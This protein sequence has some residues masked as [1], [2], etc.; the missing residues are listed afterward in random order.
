MK[1]H[2]LVAQPLVIGSVIALADHNESLDGKATVLSLV[3]HDSF[4]DVDGPTLNRYTYLV[5]T[6]PSETI[7][8]SSRG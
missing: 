8:A 4:V 1:L 7:S 5:K 6:M 2:L 3:R